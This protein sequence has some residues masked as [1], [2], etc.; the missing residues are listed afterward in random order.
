MAFRSHDWHAVLRT[1]PDLQRARP[2]PEGK[3]LAYE[4]RAQRLKEEGSNASLWFEA[5]NHVLVS[6][7]AAL[8]VL[9]HSIDRVPF[10][11]LRFPVRTSYE[12]QRV[13]LA[14]DFIQLE[15]DLLAFS[16][17]RRGRPTGSGA[18]DEF[19]FSLALTALAAALSAGRDGDTQS[20]FKARY[21]AAL[22]DR[23]KAAIEAGRYPHRG[24]M[25]ASPA[26]AHKQRIRE[27]VPRF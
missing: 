21:D 11:F 16:R 3:V 22:D 1:S 25:D 10:D 13:K 27:K 4:V 15:K 9:G 23:V 17:R 14:K 18:Y 26:K 8:E 12:Q 5:S 19:D 20:V 2:D 24:G 7:P 6:G